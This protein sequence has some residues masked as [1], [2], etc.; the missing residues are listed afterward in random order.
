MNEQLALSLINLIAVVVST[1]VAA[2]IW[3][4]VVALGYYLWKAR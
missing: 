3:V 2:T 4:L 1:G